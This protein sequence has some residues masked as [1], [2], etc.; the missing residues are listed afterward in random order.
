VLKAILAVTILAPDLEVMEQAYGKWLGYR[1]AER[2]V[3]SEQLASLW[4]APASA[5]RPYLLMQPES[6]EP[7]YLRFIETP[8]A[9]VEPMKTLGWGSTELLVTDPDALAAQ[10]EGSPFKIVGPPRPLSVDPK[11]RVMQVIGPANE[12]LY[13]TRLLPDAAGF[14][15]GTART[16]VDRVFIMVVG[17]PKM[18]VMVEFYKGLLGL[19]VTKPFPARVDV[20]NRAYGLGQENEITMALAPLPKRFLI[21]IDEFPSQ[22]AERPREEGELPPG[23]AMVSFEVVTLDAPGLEP[24]APP[25]SI[26]SAPYAGRRAAVVRGPAGE[27]LELVEASTP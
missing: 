10:L 13:L 20:I 3:I 22:A 19:P 16:F 5:G 25:A 6:G 23:V 26:G 21:E 11:I 14:N 1:V 18:E 15:L 4:G 17:G 7:V 8:G 9:G 12:M 27:L 24:L 2:G